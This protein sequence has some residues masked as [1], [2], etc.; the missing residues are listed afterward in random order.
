VK[1]CALVLMALLSLLSAGC[2]VLR[3]VE[4]EIAS[5]PPVAPVVERPASDS[6]KLLMYFG[7]VRKLSAAG[8]AKEYETVRQHRAQ[9]TSDS[10]RVRYAIVLS[11]PGSAFRD[12]AR[13]LE[14][15]EPLLRKPDA[16]L[17]SLAFMVSTQ[18]EEQRR[19]QGL[20]QKLE[21]LKSLEKSLI[22]R[23]PGAIKRR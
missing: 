14:A 20:Y 1:R 10:N 18:I 5:E 16:A 19:A 22:E 3:S 9:T 12:D 17:H 13:A 21:A 15:L 7:H 11:V 6:E 23:D 8:L 4:P 2:G